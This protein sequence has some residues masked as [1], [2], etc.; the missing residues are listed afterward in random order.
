VQGGRLLG[1]RPRG[2]IVILGLAVTVAVLVLAGAGLV[3]VISARVHEIASGALTTA[4]GRH[5]TIGK[6]SGDLWSGVVLEDL[7]LAPARPGEP[8]PLSARRLTIH[9]DA[10]GAVRDLLGRQGLAA[11]IARNLTQIVLD[12]PE[13]RVTHAATGVWDFTQ[14]LSTRPGTASPAGF[15]GRI[16]ILDG[17]VTLIDRRRIAPGTF[18]ARFSDLNGTVDFARAPRVA[19]RA[20]FVE[21]RDGRSTSGRLG[22]AYLLDRRLLDVDLHAYGLDAAVWGQYVLTTPA[23]RVTGGQVDARLHIL[24]TP[25]GRG[26]VTDV[27]GRLTVRDGRASFPGRPAALSGIQ[28]EIDIS[29]RA[30]STARL[31]GIFNGARVEMRGDVSFYGEPRINVAARTDAADL[32]RLGRLFFPGLVSRL[33]G[34]VRGDVWITGPISAPRLEGRV[35]A[36]RGR[37]DRQPFDRASGDIALYGG[38]F[39]LLDARFSSGGGS[40]SGAG[41]WTL[42]GPQFSMSLRADGV[43][44]SALRPWT[45][46]ALSGLDGRVRGT[47]TLTRQ[48]P[49]LAWAGQASLDGGIVRGVALDALDASFRADARSNIALEHVT[50]RRGASLASASGSVSSRGAL[51]LDALVSTPDLT[52]LPLPRLPGDP[53]GRLDFAG[54]VLGTL[55]APELAGF[56]LVRDARLAG[57]TFDS[58]AGHFSAR[59]GHLELDSVQARSGYARYRVAGGA[60]WTGSLRS[61][62]GPAL[63]LDFEAERAPAG[64]F[65]AVTGMTVPISGLV[66]GR[67]RVEGALSRP[68]AAG[69][70]SLRDAETLG[71]KI[72]EA[73]TAF[74]WDGRRL[75]L[76]GALV[77]RLTS[78]VRVA[79]TFDRL[80]GLAFDVSARGLDLQDITL[81]QAGSTRIE[82]RI[83]LVGRIT[84]SPANPTAAVEASA[85][86]LTVNGLRFDSATGTIRW[87]DRAVRLDPVALRVGDERYEISGQVVLAE[88]SHISLTSSVTGGRLSTLLGLA[89]A[90]LGV[91]LDGTINGTATLDGPLA[92]PTARLELTM[93]TGRLGDHPLAGH[94]DLTLRDNAVTIQEL[95]F[96]SRQGRVAAVG[97]YDLGG[98]SQV[99][100]SGADLEL[101]IL[102]PLFKLRRPLLG[103]LNFTMQLSGTLATPELGLDVEV[104]KGGVAG[105]TFD[106]LVVSAFYRDGLLQLVQGLLAQ[107][108]HKLRASG[109]IPFNPKSLRFD[110]QAPLDFK[111][112][113]ADVNLSLLRLLTD[114]VED[115]RGDIAG[116]LTVGGTVAAPRLGGDLRV[117]GGTVKL[118]GV[119]TPIEA[120]VLNVVFDGNAMRV[121]QASARLGGGT[122][123]LDGVMRLTLARSN[124][125]AL[126]IPQDTPFVLQASNVRLDA[127]PLVNARFDGSVRLWGASGDA[128]RPL[129]AD[130]RIVVSEGTLAVAG[131]SPGAEAGRIFPLTFQ[132]LQFVAG[133]DL[134]LQAGG[135]RVTLKP[136]GSLLLTGTM[137]APMLEGTLEA[138]R[139]PVTVL[140]NTFDLQEGSA[141]FRPALG[142][143]PQVSAAGVTQVGPARITL[144]IHG[145]APDALTL[146][147]RSDPSLSQQE[148]L[149][150][151]SRQSGISDLLAGD[152]AGLLRAE[153]TR[154][155]LAPVTAAI[156]RALGLSELTVDYDFEQ[157]LRLT[158]GKLLLPNLYVTAITT[159]EEQTRW[160]WA[161]EYRFAPGWQFA[162]RVGQDGRISAIFWYATRI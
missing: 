102:R 49:G 42:G 149:A 1:R 3:G 157:P 154:R 21:H 92:K 35:H 152:V 71:Q 65:T 119:R 159:F 160:L 8:S 135:L 96:T 76:E 20:S 24:R 80:T 113:M 101:D 107:D 70:V 111:V 112:G 54:R 126:E 143:R 127:P 26:A 140:G 142:V 12:E 57:M 13:V 27:S 115:A 64:L 25:A 89:G 158:V 59:G 117:D 55:Q 161:L 141:T 106:S 53:A 120:L 81:P 146:D 110:D 79:G 82:G 11:S 22:G 72:D 97:R 134:A 37:F 41:V 133:R 136:E 2:A 95:E 125:A 77:R 58:L 130:G 23:F 68:S 18:E 16:I 128:R 10:R 33:T 153:I 84:G 90:R 74:R 98:E 67:V 75:T 66:D 69:F 145:T 4:M 31:R 162:F 48:G 99:E 132:G 85:A 7:T 147:L 103:R 123:R 44:A 36:A 118:R 87:A 40:L 39:G 60:R 104:T 14:L 28:G 17:R 124:G 144:E 109:S 93:P 43:A 114:R 61:G 155:L 88:A 30:V 15:R 100:V 122:A 73:S 47:L 29:D 52:S 34:V 94:V 129:T 62:R 91:P 139:G 121:A 86:D 156:V 151:L 38:L 116:T 78:T 19:L 56:V 6:A 138:Q 32:T 50:V 108:G 5:V 131:G 46:G 63:A 45:P 83:N 137:A 148:I 9:L 51:A 150:L 105:A